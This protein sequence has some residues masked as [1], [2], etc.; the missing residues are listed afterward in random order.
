MPPNYLGLSNKKN[1]LSSKEKD[2]D[3]NSFH[4]RSDTNWNINDDS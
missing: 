1:N 4:E 2:K 3:N